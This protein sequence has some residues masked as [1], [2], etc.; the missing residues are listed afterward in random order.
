M[1]AHIHVTC[2]SQA[3]SSRL[4]LSIFAALVFSAIVGGWVW[5][6][7]DPW[8]FALPQKS[9]QRVAVYGARPDVPGLIVDGD[10]VRLAFFRPGSCTGCDTGFPVPAAP[11][12]LSRYYDVHTSHDSRVRARILEL[13]APM[14]GFGGIPQALDMARRRGLA[15][16]A[17]QKP[18]A[19]NGPQYGDFIVLDWGERREQNDITVIH[20]GCATRQTDAALDRI[21]KAFE[22][23]AE[24]TNTGTDP[25]SRFRVERL[26]TD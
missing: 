25:R 14:K 10:E 24:A 11:G 12:D 8:A 17:A 6:R 13:L 15:Q 9:V 22:I 23:A 26:T 5:C 19:C 7:H 16:F 4:H 21:A 1:A 20:P 18:I 2:R 3:M